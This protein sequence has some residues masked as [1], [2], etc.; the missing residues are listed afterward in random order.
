M[1]RGSAIRSGLCLSAL[2]VL[3]AV[4][5]ACRSVP[6]GGVTIALPESVVLVDAGGIP[7]VFHQTTGPTFVTITS[8]DALAGRSVNGIYVI[9]DADAYG[10]LAV[11]GFRVQRRE[12]AVLLRWGSATFQVTPGPGQVVLVEGSRVGTS[13]R[14]YEQHRDLLDNIGATGTVAAPAPVSLPATTKPAAEERP[15]G[16]TPKP[17]SQAPAATEKPAP[18]PGEDAVQPEPPAPDEKPE[19]QQPVDQGDEGQ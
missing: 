15:A 10:E 8:Q 7:V 19:E 13:D 16:P 6:R 1:T 2:A 3:L 12:N 9:E 4:S 5:P 14:W 11:E 17:E 18:V